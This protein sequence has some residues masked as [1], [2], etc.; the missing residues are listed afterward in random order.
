MAWLLLTA[1]GIPPSQWRLILLPFNGSL[2][3]YMPQ[4]QSLIKSIRQTEHLMN[5][6]QKN[7]WRATH[8]KS[9]TAF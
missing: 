5:I 6:A 1:L 2:P 9:D 7:P 8:Y 3:E 4:Y